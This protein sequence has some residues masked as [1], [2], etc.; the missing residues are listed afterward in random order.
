MVSKKAAKAKAQNKADKIKAEFQKYGIELKEDVLNDSQ[1]QLLYKGFQVIRIF[2]GVNKMFLRKK[3]DIGSWN[4]VLE[5]SPRREVIE[6]MAKIIK[7][8]LPKS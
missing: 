4:S 1:C 3:N 6:C 2:K 5:G 8:D 7:N